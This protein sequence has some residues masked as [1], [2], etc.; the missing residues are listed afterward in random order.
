[1]T[2]LLPKG[3]QCWYR[4]C[5]RPPHKLN[6]T[7][8]QFDLL[9]WIDS[10][11]KS[12]FLKLL[13]CL[14]H[15]LRPLETIRFISEIIWHLKIKSKSPVNK[16]NHSCKKFKSSRT[17]H[18]RKPKQF[19]LLTWQHRYQI[20]RFNNFKEAEI[21]GENRFESDHDDSVSAVALTWK[22]HQTPQSDWKWCQILQDLTGYSGDTRHWLW[23]KPLMSLSNHP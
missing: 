7:G 18:A 4:L 11:F 17:D 5:C 12:T 22:P 23:T 16:R 15:R 3:T 13:P 21:A 14:V 9:W 1:M 8:I 6:L 20:C 2:V 10:R 19:A